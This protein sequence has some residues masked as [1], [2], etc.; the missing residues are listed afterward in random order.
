[1]GG[2]SEPQEGVA[3]LYILTKR[4]S[5]DTHMTTL[6]TLLFAYNYRRVNTLLRAQAQ[7]IRRMAKYLSLPDKLHVVYPNVYVN[8]LEVRPQELRRN[9][10]HLT[11]PYCTGR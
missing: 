4:A 1:M 11:V 2:S 3:T 5:D 7:R 9:Q 6:C 8:K 10:V